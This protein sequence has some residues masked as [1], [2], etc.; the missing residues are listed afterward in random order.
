MA[1]QGLT[2]VTRVPSRI[3]SV[4]VAAAVDAGT[5]PESGLAPAAPPGQVVVG[6]DRMK[7]EVIGPPSELLPLAPPVDGED[8]TVLSHM[9]SIPAP[10]TATSAPQAP[11]VAYSAATLIAKLASRTF[12]V[13]YSSIEVRAC[14]GC[15][16]GGGVEEVCRFGPVPQA[17]PPDQ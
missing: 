1:E 14:S 7:A 6:T 17:R 3:R 2:E 12:D 15:V 4:A 5:A 11:G 13:Y 9:P 8:P 16:R 10:S